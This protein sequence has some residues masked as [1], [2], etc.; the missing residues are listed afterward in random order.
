MKTE[1]AKN[2]GLEL[3]VICPSY[4]IGPSLKP[5]SVNPSNEI[6]Q[7]IM[8][9]EI[10]AIIN[11]AFPQVDVRDVARAHISIDG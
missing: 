2:S 8:T 11:L 9:R 10:P 1:T 4:V 5:T 7:K 3:A 6:F